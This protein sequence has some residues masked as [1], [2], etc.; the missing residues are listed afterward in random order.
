[1]LD[2]FETDWALVWRSCF[3]VATLRP[4]LDGGLLKGD[5]KV[6]G[7]GARH[8]PRVGLSFRSLWLP[9]ERN[10]RGITIRYI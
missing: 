8:A 5:P 2:L 4:N 6:R 3:R 9:D 7:A 1:M 10:G